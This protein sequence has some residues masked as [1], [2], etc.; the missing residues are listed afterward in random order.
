MDDFYIELI[1]L[2][3]IMLQFYQK[4]CVS[5][6]WN[7]HTRH[8]K[9]FYD[10]N[11]TESIKEIEMLTV[12]NSWFVH[13]SIPFCLFYLALIKLVGSVEQDYVSLLTALISF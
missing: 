2:Y 7:V 1:D 8:L 5:L 3:F 12:Q 11:K 9:S 6:L 10:K 13:S 4:I